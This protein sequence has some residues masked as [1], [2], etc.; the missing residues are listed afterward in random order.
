ML[1]RPKSFDTSHPLGRAREP[2]DYRAL[3]HDIGNDSATHAEQ[4]NSVF[5]QL[6]DSAE[7]ELCVA[8][9]GVGTT[10]CERDCGGATIRLCVAVVGAD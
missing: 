7:G 6:V 4:I 5:D 3:T 2:A 10:G 1:R 9:A 8:V